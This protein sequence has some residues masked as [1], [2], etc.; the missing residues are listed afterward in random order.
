MHTVTI[1]LSLNEGHDA[2]KAETHDGLIEAVKTFEA[3]A[4]AAVVGWSDGYD[5]PEPG[6]VAPDESN[7]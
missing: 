7:A 6:G 5:T 1:R 2:N 3:V 4:D